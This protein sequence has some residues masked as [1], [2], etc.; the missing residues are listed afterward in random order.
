[1]ELK[2]QIVGFASD[3][4]SCFESCG[5]TL[6][7]VTRSGPNVDNTRLVVQY[8]TQD[9]TA[10]RN[11]N[12]RPVDK[13]TIELNP[14]Q[15]I[16]K[17]LISILNDDIFEEQ[18][19]KF[20][21]C[22]TNPVLTDCSTGNAEKNDRNVT[23]K[24]KD[25]TVAIM[26]DDHCGVFMFEC[27]QTPVPDNV[28]IFSVKVIRAVGARGRIKVPFTVIP[29]TAKEVQD[30]IPLTKRFVTF[31]NGQYETEIDIRIKDK[32]RH[33]HVLTFYVQ[34]ETPTKITNDI[35]LTIGDPILGQRRLLQL[36]ICE[37]TE[38]REAM[39]RII[40]KTDLVANIV[41]FTWKDQLSSLFKVLPTHHP[42][43]GGGGGSI[44]ISTCKKIWLYFIHIISFPWK[45]LIALLPPSGFAQGYVA[46]VLLLC[47]MIV[48]AA[49]VADCAGY[50]GCTIGL[51]VELTAMTLIS[52][53]L[54][55]PGTFSSRRA[56]ILEKT[57]DKAIASITRSNVSTKFLGIGIAWLIGSIY[58]N[59]KG[60]E[61]LVS[62]F[63][64]TTTKI[65]KY[66][67]SFFILGFI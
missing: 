34:L 8:H 23:I 24:V 21:V 66:F 51:K 32:D 26:D 57:A 58:Q 14:G 64:T 3:N 61:F 41:A 48:I 28:G 12:F 1:M 45:A 31:E 50:L 9:M 20:R 40:Q 6:I 19:K 27:D 17:I 7:T 38:M 67:A 15:R 25:C 36:G 56:A 54:C 49:L 13:G 42:S 60:K 11:V 59:T 55:L 2:S 18:T 30:Y 63:L 46:Y 52:F 4:H 47:V 29:G 43:T 35:K 16:G 22:L 37:D 62:F 10:K 33:G 65:D 44:Q 53:G 5:A 39:N